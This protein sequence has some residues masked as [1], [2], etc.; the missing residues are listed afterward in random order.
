M[1]KERSNQVKIRGQ[2]IEFAP[3]ALNRLL[4]TPNVDPQPFVDLVK[5]PP[6]RNIRHNLYGPNSV[7]WWTCHQQL[8]YHV[9]L[10]YAHL[11]RE[12]RVWLKIVCACLVPGKHVT[13][14]IRERVFLVYALMTGIPINVGVLIKNVLKRAKLRIWGSLDPIMRGHDIEEEEAD[15]RPTYDPRRVDVTK[16]KEPKGINSLFLAVNER[17]ARIDN[18]LSHLY[19]GPG[20]DEPL[21][22]DVATEDEMERVDS[23]IESS[24]DD[25]EDSEM[26]EAA[27]A[28]T[29]NEE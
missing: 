20:Y 7:A 25:E 22:D 14:V 23:D 11:S 18:M 4:G 27:L 10:P 28:P 26:R 3:K 19:I 2:I 13:Y 29:D 16:T 1:P 24:D 17:N 15:Y 9:S 12:A 6:Y 8:G 5:K 21:D